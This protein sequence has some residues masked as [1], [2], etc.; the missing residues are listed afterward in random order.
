MNTQLFGVFE[1]K[2]TEFVHTYY[3]YGIK[4][5][6]VFTLRL[7]HICHMVFSGIQYQ[8]SK[9]LAVISL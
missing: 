5:G 2:I 4:I 7:G 1:I 8:Q 9:M 3:L 6:A